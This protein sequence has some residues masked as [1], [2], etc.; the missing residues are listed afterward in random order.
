MATS[1]RNLGPVGCWAGEGGIQDSK[2]HSEYIHRLTAGRDMHV[3]ITASGETGVGKTTLAFAL[4][5]MWDQTGWTAHKACVAD[6]QKYSRLYDDDDRIHPGSVLLLD[7]A[8]K[9]VDARR[10]MKKESVQL[11]QDFASKRYRQI[12]GLLTAPSK[13][14]VDKRL[15]S[16]S[17]DYWI[18]AQE[19]DTGK[20]KGEAVVYRLKENEHYEREYTTREE[21]VS[22][23]VLDW[24]PEFR[25]LDR[26]KT[27]Q[28]SNNHEEQTTY[29]EEEVEKKLKKRYE[30][31]LK[32]GEVSVLT[33]IY[34]NTQLSQRD[35]ANATTYSLSTINQRLNQ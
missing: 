3:I 4:A 32:Q 29:T 14:W 12:F 27:E 1:S 6:A 33:D 21:V 18:Q 20:P 22:W 11:S 26:I 13:S 10:S 5:M 30:E 16:S 25:R 2:L 31:G 28:L 17:A 7:E 19:T 35:L 23:P 15:G 9:A 34:H 8:E 24:H